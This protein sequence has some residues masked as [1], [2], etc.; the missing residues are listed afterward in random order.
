MFIGHTI[1]I[2]LKRRLEIVPITYDASSS[3]SLVSTEF[4]LSL[5]L[6][7]SPDAL[8]IPTGTSLIL[9]FNVIDPFDGVTLAPQL[10]AERLNAERTYLDSLAL[11]DIIITNAETNET[12]NLKRPVELVFQINGTA[13]V[14][15]GELIPAW[16]FNEERGVWIEEG[17]GV[18]SVSPEGNFSWSFN[19]SRLN[20]W[21]CDRPWTDKNC[22]NVSVSH[23]QNGD[24]AP[25][26]LSGALVSVRG[27]SYNYYATIPTALTGETCVEAKKG[28]LSAIRAIHS[29]FD[30]E[31]GEVLVYGSPSPSYC[32]S[33]SLLWT[34]NLLGI[35]GE[36]EEVNILCKNISICLLLYGELVCLV[37]DCGSLDAPENGSVHHPLTVS[38]YGSVIVIATATFSCHSEFVLSGESE[39]TCLETGLWSGPSPDCR[40]L[41]ADIYFVVSYS[42][43]CCRAIC[44]SDYT[45]RNKASDYTRCNKFDHI[46]NN[47]PWAY[48]SGANDSWTY[49]SGTNDSWTY[50]SISNDSWIYNSGSNDSWTYNTG[51]NDSCTYN[52]GSN[53]SWTYNSRS[54]D[55]WAYNSGSND[56][57]T[58]NS[59]SNDSWAYNSGT[60][61]SWTYNSGSNDSWTYN[62]GANDSWTYNSGS[63]DSWIYNSRAKWSAFD[64]NRN[65]LLRQ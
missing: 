30:F 45:S 15:D 17:L 14:T 6:H 18:V 3:F 23:I 4:S 40:K 37:A 64:T 13:N 16:S 35:G 42:F 21:N 28:E 60:N 25:S 47:D 26:P 46:R 33:N 36:C 27:L 20:W 59:G 10:L 61:D 31:S 5:T 38:V 7:F 57:W 55:S 65:P 53:D 52:S 9:S 34:P 58:Y 41:T 50:N 54:N 51:A 48:N 12:V 43:F 11:G 62:T 63:N 39:L 1:V 19:A 56:S 24:A 8:D 32:E 49:N 22:I 29:L 44:D 2:T